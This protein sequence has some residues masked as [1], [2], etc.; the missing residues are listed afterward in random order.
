MEF[1]CGHLEAVKNLKSTTYHNARK[2]II[3][4]GKERYLVE[5]YI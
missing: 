3:L 1:P 2:Q 5:D 4:Q